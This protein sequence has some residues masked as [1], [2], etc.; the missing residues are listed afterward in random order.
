M[1]RKGGEDSLVGL[2]LAVE[3]GLSWNW[4]SRGMGESHCWNWRNSRVWGIE[5]ERLAGCHEQREQ[6]FRDAQTFS[7]HASG[8][9]RSMARGFVSSQAQA[10][11]WAITKAP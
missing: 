4:S 10:P 3:A 9:L 5:S 8:L 7:F 1:G 11:L 6:S 2:D